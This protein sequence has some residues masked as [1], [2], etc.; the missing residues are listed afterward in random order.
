MQ[1]GVWRFV[2]G[3]RRLWRLTVDLLVLVSRGE[4]ADDRGDGLPAGGGSKHFRFAAEGE[5]AGDD[6]EVVMGGDGDD[7]AAVRLLFNLLL[8]VPGIFEDPACAA[9]GDANFEVAGLAAGEDADALPEMSF[10]VKIGRLLKEGVE[11]RRPQETI[12]LEVANAVLSLRNFMGRGDD[13]QTALI[14]NHGVRLDLAILRVL[15]RRLILGL[16]DS[17]FQNGPVDRAQNAVL[18]LIAL[19]GHAADVEH[20]P[21]GLVVLPNRAGQLV[22]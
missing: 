18:P 3:R 19:G 15:A 7:D 10:Q 21:I 17:L 8:G 11:R 12:E 20:L 2:S 14:E 4:L 9:L 1:R 13:V 6:F 16:D 22:L 5:D